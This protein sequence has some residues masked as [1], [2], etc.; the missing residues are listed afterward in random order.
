[1]KGVNYLFFKHSSRNFLNFQDIWISKLSAPPIISNYLICVYTKP[2]HIKKEFA[3][4]LF[5]V[6]K[7]P[8]VNHWER[9][10]SLNSQSLKTFWTHEVSEEVPIL[11][12]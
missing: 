10:P 11:A 8:F 6:L 3:F 4:K 12:L 7:T 5:E 9:I 2:K 1:M